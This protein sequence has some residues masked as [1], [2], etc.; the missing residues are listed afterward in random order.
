M[1]FWKYINDARHC[2]KQG[3]DKSLRS[4]IENIFDYLDDN[5][6]NTIGSK[7]K[8][9][10]D[11]VATYKLEGIV[12]NISATRETRPHKK[13]NDIDLETYVQEVAEGI[14]LVTCCMN[15]NENLLKAIPSWIDCKE[16]NEIIIVDWSSNEAVY[17]YLKY[18]GITDK[19]IK[20]IRVDNQPSWVLSYAFNIGFR[21]SSFS[22]ILKTD[23]DIIIKPD[24]F[25]KN[26]LQ[27]NIFISGDWRSA[28]K[29][30]EHINGFFF[31]DRQSLMSIKGFNEYIT[32][33]G[34]DDDDIYSRL[35]SIG[36]TRT[37]V[38]L[39]TI[40]HI[41]HGDELR[42]DSNSSGNEPLNDLHKSTRFKIRT[43]RF[44]ANAMPSWTKDRVFLPFKI[45][46][47]R[48]NYLKLEQNGESV[49]YVPKHIRDD[50]EYYTELELTSWQAG[51]RTFDLDR[52]NLR[53]LLAS[54][55]LS[56]INRL[57][58]EIAIHNQ[59]SNF[60]F[61][62]N[63][64]VIKISPDIVN[65]RSEHIP[66][67]ID[68]I[69]KLTQKLNYGLILAA[70][71]RAQ[72][73]PYLSE[74][75][76]I[77]F[78]PSWRNLDISTEFNIDSDQEMIP[79]SGKENIQLS[80]E[81]ATIAKICQFFDRR[82]TP[83]VLIK[84]DKLF[85]DAQHGLGNRL[86]AI[87]SGAAIAAATDRELV[88]V[89][90]PDHHCECRL[91][92]LYNYTGA[93]IEK[94][95]VTDA[96][97]KDF[98]VYNYM[99]IEA[100]ANKD[101]PIIVS[102]GKDIYARSAYV[103]NSEFTEWEKENKFLR[104]LTPVEQIRDLV[105]PFDTKNRIGAHVRMEAGK[106][107]DHNTYDS[108]ENWTQEGHDLL[109]YWRDKSHYSHFI[110]RIDQLFSENPNQK[111]FLATDL[112]ETY[113]VFEE[114]YGDKLAYLKRNAYDRSREQIIFALADA[115]LLSRCQQLLGSTWSSFS[116]LAMRLSTTYSKIEMSGKDF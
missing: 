105:A 36:L 104:T 39:N 78:V 33:Y 63:Y 17:D 10:N 79:A 4:S 109:H 77:G 59:S 66:T 22:K 7:E 67:I 16:I 71:T 43:N 111:L 58:I 30:Q 14:S 21:A 54:K 84:R 96:Y 91:S 69:F 8:F 57:D 75:K 46:E 29:G 62:E 106:G 110:K 19:R 87:A 55:F 41:P 11:F 50:A 47:Q 45:I 89:W 60:K 101:S 116:E 112:P 99:E 65:H 113:K 25:E 81:L 72:V 32:T 34:W 107:L 49:H 28:A 53:K 64:F 92:D 20:I 85:I 23:A 15:R 6:K 68:A 83:E 2:L 27:E 61:S 56:S 13:S 108:I 100:G 5:N 38:D 70:E 9:F 18:H 35:G 74:E 48:N 95:F 115:I 1:L 80:L 31:V 37:L 103:L 40:Y 51:L 97:N 98:N 82:I 93:V 24:F 3:D 76:N 102:A 52:I 86:R 26:S 90:E 114:Y 73:T 94:S 44:I 42:V 88:I 12:R